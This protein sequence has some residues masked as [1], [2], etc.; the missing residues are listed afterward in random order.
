MN[1]TL[2]TDAA[3]ANLPGLSSCVIVATL[4]SFIAIMAANLLRRKPNLSHGILLSALV[5]IVATPILCWVVPKSIGIAWVSNSKTSSSPLQ[6][7]RKIDAVPSLQSTFAETE[8]PSPIKKHT[9]RLVSPRRANV[10]PA[11]HTSTFQPRL[12][13]TNPAF[14]RPQQLS[15]PPATFGRPTTFS[16]TALLTTGLLIWFCT[17]VVLLLRLTVQVISLLAVFQKPNRCQAKVL[18]DAFEDA[19]KVV[20]KTQNVQL[21]I[22]IV[23]TPVAMNWPRRQVVI[24]DGLADQ[25]DRPSLRRI[26]THELAHVRRNDQSVLFFQ[27]FVT[28]FLWPFVPIHFL[29]RAISQTREDLCDNYIDRKEM[30]EYCND[31]LIMML[32]PLAN[33]KA[34]QGLALVP[35]LFSRRNLEHRISGILSETR[36]YENRV[37]LPVA[38][39]IAGSMLATATAAASIS[40]QATEKPTEEKDT[41]LYITSFEKQEPGSLAEFEPLFRSLRL[42]ESRP[43]NFELKID[44]GEKSKNHT[45]Q[46][47]EIRYG[48]DASDQ[49]TVVVV[50]KSEATTKAADFRL[51]LDQNRDRT[52]DESELINS[53][54]NDAPL[55]RT[56]SLEC[57]IQKSDDVNKAD[58]LDRTVAFR[59]GI[60]ADRIG[61]A[62]IGFMQGQVTLDG[63]ITQMRRMDATGNGLFNDR[64]DRVWID[65]N[66]DS[67]WG[68]DEQFKLNPIMLVGD[69]R[70]RVRAHSQKNTFRLEP[71]TETGNIKLILPL[72]DKSATIARLRV[73]FSGNNG[74]GFTLNGLKSA[75][76][77]TGEYDITNVSVVVSETETSP[78]Q[79]FVFTQRGQASGV[80]RKIKINKDANLTIDPIGELRLAANARESVVPGGTLVVGL[81]L[82]TTDGLAVSHSDIGVRNGAIHSNRAAEVETRIEN[83]ASKVISGAISGFY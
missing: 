1:L 17:T 11:S 69:S 55:T 41:H 51:Y 74:T 9:G 15:S 4:V 46:F 26:F 49:V 64:E 43:T 14:A 20:G 72:V 70:Y 42:S 52:I 35:G 16:F 45:V 65:T 38:I 13:Q 30:V 59:R 3:F 81:G 61:F 50:S 62:T 71:V 31:L 23:Q 79:S 5:L 28:C 22:A 21:R 25:L 82:Y 2:I 6:T 73:T 75:T 34:A 76:V 66:R 77:P 80:G 63:K 10:H 19:Q 60:L 12:E 48:S 44:L 32:L 83:H 7:P 37:G 54:L 53:L 33:R 18:Q 39:L 27:K 57:L 24:P 8:L 47:G 36:S 68:I 67:H 40:F 56:C 78:S 58:R 29:N